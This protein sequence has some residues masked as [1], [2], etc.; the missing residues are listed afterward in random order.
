MADMGIG[1]GIADRL[2]EAGAS[3][4]IADLDAAIAERSAATLEQRRPDSAF[5]VAADVSDA[6]DVDAMV[7]ATVDRFGGLDILVNN[8]GIYPLATLADIDAATF[9]RVLDVNLVGLFLCTRAGSRQM[10]AQGRGG[11]IINITSIDALHPSAIGLAHYDASKH[12]AWGFTKNVALELAQ[13]GIRVNAI[14]PGGVATPGTG[15]V[16]GASASEELA[17]LAQEMTTRIPMRRFGDADEIGRVALFLATDLSSY[18]TGAQ[19]IVDGGV[20]LR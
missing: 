20:L 10:I 12:G 7:Q 5:A 3:I 14:A 13:H 4:V 19:V 17:T 18:M 1:R 11:N 2:H 6:A 16:D 9:R 15:M 8:A